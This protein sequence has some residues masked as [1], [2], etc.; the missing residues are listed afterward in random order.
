M[1]KVL[2]GP[3]TV[4]A[5]GAL[6]LFVTQCSDQ[7]AEIADARMQVVSERLDGISKELEILR[8]DLGPRVTRLE[9]RYLSRQ[10]GSASVELAKAP[11]SDQEP[12]P[13]EVP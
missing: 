11:A 12:D 13:W 8:S 9:D 3:L 4:A 5:V 7:S 10:D 2:A 6:S 1:W